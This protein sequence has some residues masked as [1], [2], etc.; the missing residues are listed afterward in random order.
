MEEAKLLRSASRG[1]RIGS[2]RLW[3][4]F[5]RGLCDVVLS[6][7]RFRPIREILRLRMEKSSMN[8]GLEP[9][10]RHRNASINAP[11]DRI[12]GT[13]GRS[14][15]MSVEERGDSSFV[16]LYFFHAQWWL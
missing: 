8:P 2:V 15:I 4:R 7:I 10:K 11:I 1:L 12:T 14:R 16:R 5:V 3:R 6:E 13:M 9:A